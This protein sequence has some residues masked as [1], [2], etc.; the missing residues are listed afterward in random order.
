M[1]AWL[2]KIKGLI[3][4][5]YP[6]QNGG[7]AIAEILFGQTNPSG[8]LPVTFEKQWPDNPVFGN[9]YQNSGPGHVK[10]NEGIFVG[11]R[12]Y[13]VN[14]IE[15]QFPFGFGLSY[16]TFNYS[17]LVISK[18][19]AGRNV[20]SFDIKNT[21]K[22][23]GAEAAQLYISPVSPKVSRPFKEL[24][25]FAKVYLE[26]GETKTVTM[27][28][29]DI[30]FSYYSTARNSFVIDSGKYEVIIGAS[31]RDKRLWN[32]ISI[33][34]NSVVSGVNRFFAE[35]KD[36]TVFPNPATDYIILQSNS[37]LPAKRTVQVLN[38]NG[39]VVDQ[40]IQ[41]SQ[42]YQYNCNHL[43]DGLYIF[44]INSDGKIVTRKFMVI[45]K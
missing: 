38:S 14:N 5:W 1:N 28:L 8:K 35:N 41:N 23:A 29:D 39:R 27:I 13:D 42:S 24:K 34:R 25:D 9:Y 20:V 11:Y 22:M 15:P 30:A 26:P 10:Y 16:T 45:R 43:P 6:G 19:T 40:F 17:N 18:D 3:Y 32:T 7:K 12:Y 37:A 36:I 4:A 21:G 2:K 44:R 31:S 33:D